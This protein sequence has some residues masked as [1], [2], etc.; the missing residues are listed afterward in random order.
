VVGG[1][2]AGVLLVS[3]RAKIAGSTSAGSRGSLRKSLYENG[4]SDASV[5]LAGA[6]AEDGARAVTFRPGAGL[7]VNGM[8]PFRGIEAGAGALILG[9]GAE[10]I[11]NGIPLLRRTGAGMGAGVGMLRPGPGFMLEVNAEF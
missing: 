8:L 1:L 7:M 10:T 5:R 3:V 4:T 9:P 11:L 2:D 6:G